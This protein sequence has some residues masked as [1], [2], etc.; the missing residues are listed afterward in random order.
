MLK[1]DRPRYYRKSVMKM[2]SVLTDYDTQTAQALLDIY[3]EHKVY[4]ANRMEE[5]AKDMC[6]RM[7]NADRKPIVI[8]LDIRREDIT[9]EKR[10]IGVY[11]AIIGE[12]GER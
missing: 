1:A 8:P 5:I 12:G 9:P 10:S 2:S 4:N 6:N 3:L 7:E 11:R